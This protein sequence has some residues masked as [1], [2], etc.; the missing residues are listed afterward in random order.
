MQS[1]IKES[2]PNT[3]SPVWKNINPLIK[4]VVPSLPQI[5]TLENF[6]GTSGELVAFEA[7]QTDEKEIG[8]VR[9]GNFIFLDHR[10]KPTFSQ[11]AL[12]K[13]G[14]D[15][16]WLWNFDSA[17]GEYTNLL[18]AQL[19]IHA[20]S[21]LDLKGKHVL[22][23]GAGDGVQ[24]LVAYK[25]GAKKVSSVELKGAHEFFYNKHLE[26][27]GFPRD[28][29][30]FIQGDIT[31]PQI[32]MEK[33]DSQEVDVVIANIGPFYEGDPH[34]HAISLLSYLPNVQTFIA[35][36]YVRGWS[37]YDSVKAIELLKTLGFSTNFREL[38]FRGNGQTF[39]HQAFI[40]EKDKQEGK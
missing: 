37:E 15:I 18:Y 12:E 29:F 33:L 38:K 2:A 11:D 26:V 31:K 3:I 27:N 14:N 1:N 30:E 17:I 40:I 20:L 21:T 35:G 19:S 32:L 7:R 13:F 4:E 10:L 6:V 9:V 34:L 28:G 23:L 22:D 8:F 24:S 36:A 16:I 25:M 39:Y 5:V